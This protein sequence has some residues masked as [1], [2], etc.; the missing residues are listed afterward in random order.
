[1]TVTLDPHNFI[2]ESLRTHLVNNMTD[3]LG[4]S[5][6]SNK[7]FITI[8]PS[9]QQP[10]YPYINI[11]MGGQAPSFDAGLG[12]VLDSTHKAKELAPSV[13][14]MI[15]TNA[16]EAPVTIS[17]AG[18][19]RHKLLYYL[20]SQVQRYVTQLSGK[21]TL[22]GTYDIKN[23]ELN[24]EDEVIGPD[25]DGEMFIAQFYDAEFLWRHT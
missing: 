5:R 3:P 24:S 1:M 11:K 4:V 7:P 13:K 14:V 15:F 18:Y 21:Q 23:I 2:L 25:D 19:S 16:E 17:S 9:I 22:E 10:Q 20:A 12:E 6:D 8:G